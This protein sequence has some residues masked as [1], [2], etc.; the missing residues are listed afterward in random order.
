MHLYRS[1]LSSLLQLNGVPQLFTNSSPC[2][3]PAYA[4]YKGKNSHSC[5][6][7]L[8]NFLFLLLCCAFHKG[9]DHICPFIVYAP[10]FVIVCNQYSFD[11][12]NKWMN[13]WMKWMSEWMNMNNNYPKHCDIQKRADCYKPSLQADSS[14]AL[15]VH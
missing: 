15:A 2:L 13:E 1:S 6:C 7:L 10:V 14:L 4:Y 9:S 11:W 3:F 5:I 8:Y 12:M